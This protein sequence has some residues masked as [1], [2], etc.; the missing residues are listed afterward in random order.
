M[1]PH[2]RSAFRYPIRGMYIPPRIQPTISTL[3]SP[4]TLKRKS[5]S[6]TFG[7]CRD[8]ALSRSLQAIPPNCPG[9]AGH[10]PKLTSS[11]PPGGTA[12]CRASCPPAPGL[13]TSSTLGTSI[14]AK[15]GGFTNHLLVNCSTFSEMYLNTVMSETLRCI[16]K[17]TRRVLHHS[18]RNLQFR[19]FTNYL[20]VNCSTFSEMYLNTT[21]FIVSSSTRVYPRTDTL[22]SL[23]CLATPTQSR[24]SIFSNSMHLDHHPGRPAQLLPVLDLAKSLRSRRLLQVGVE[25]FSKD[26]S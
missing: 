13:T 2:S 6:Q 8:L 14:D 3:Q 4:A 21:D 23:L 1:F 12:P 18:C 7:S 22:F 26:T 24:Q 19:G 17:K 5:D 9:R 10:Q 15:L 20:L 11:P 16:L 25:D